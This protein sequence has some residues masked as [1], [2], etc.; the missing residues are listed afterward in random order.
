MYFIPGAACDEGSPYTRY[1][2]SPCVGLRCTLDKFSLLMLLLS[3]LCICCAIFRYYIRFVMRARPPY[4]SSSS[5]TRSPMS[6][7]M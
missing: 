7:L 1:I 2:R 6:T 5:S 4:G 3:F